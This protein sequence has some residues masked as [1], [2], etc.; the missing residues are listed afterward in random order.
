MAMATGAVACPQDLPSLIDQLLR[1]LPSYA[2]RAFRRSQPPGANGYYVILAG[3]PDFTPI[4]TD[5]AGPT[6]LQQVFFTT[7]SRQYY[8]QRIVEQ[9]EFHRLFLTQTS[10][11]WRLAMLFSTTSLGPGQPP[12]PPRETSNQA[13]GQAIA[14]WLRDCQAGSL[15]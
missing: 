14:L 10:Q 9:Q 1:D 7:L 4:T 5:L 15:R 11:G 13:F 8:G 6:N 2:N 3:N 12:T